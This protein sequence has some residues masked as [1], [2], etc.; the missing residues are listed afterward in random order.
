MRK[1]S[2]FIILLIYVCE[3]LLISPVLFKTSSV[4]KS[5]V[6]YEG[7]SRHCGLDSSLDTGGDSFNHI[8]NRRLKRLSTCVN[9]LNVARKND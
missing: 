6:A 1:P 7:E 2:H 9:E 8:I 5:Q 4:V 3:L